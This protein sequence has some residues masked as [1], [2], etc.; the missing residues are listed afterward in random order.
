[1]WQERIRQNAHK[2]FSDHGLPTRKLE[3]WHYTSVKGVPVDNVQV[4]AASS[5]DLRSVKNYISKNIPQE[6]ARI[7]FVD[8]KLVKALTDIK[9][10]SDQVRMQLGW[11]SEVIRQSREMRKLVGGVEQDAFEAINASRSETVF[12][13]TVPKNVQVRTPLV[14]L[15]F[16]QNDKTA[17]YP[18]VL[19]HMQ[20]SS[21]LTLLEQYQ[22]IGSDI[23]QNGVVE[24]ILE[25]QARLEYVRL[26]QDDATAWN[27]GRSRFF[28]KR[29]SYLNCI[30][31]GFG[32]KLARHSLEI[33]LT[34]ENA[35]ANS[36]GVYSL[37]G[38]QHHDHHLLIDHVVGHCQTVQHYKGVIDDKARSVFDGKV[39]IRLDA[40][41]A[42]SEQLNNNL[43]LSQQAEA[44]S[45]PQLEIYA[46]DV[47]ATHGSTIGQ[48][49]QDELFYFQSRGI[50][51]EEAREMLSLGYL[52]EV[53]FQ[54]ENET[55]RNYLQSIS[56]DSYQKAR[57]R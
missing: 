56:R 9:S 18:R 5:A 26:N 47:K 34:G 45:Q 40:Q 33:Y 27:F 30:T 7:V 1:M 32:A 28:L 3:Q 6:F 52:D 43:I 20:S 23:L 38:E 55:L 35:Q 41:K 42:S 10:I 37:V 22:S 17:S 8:G 49:S 29:D 39:R 11:S 44:D 36:R 12:T 16:V 25:P 50:R 31:L 51:L 53:I 19:L 46:D 57:A 2:Y 14:I 54:V 24:S 4:G 15:S 48:L 13:L 21:Q